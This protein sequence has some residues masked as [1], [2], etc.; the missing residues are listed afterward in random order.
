M[1]LQDQATYLDEIA[2]SYEARGY[3]VQFL[4]F[5]YSAAWLPLVTATTQ[6]QTITIDHDS[7]FIC[8]QLGQSVHDTATPPVFDIQPRIQVRFILGTAQKR[9]D[10]IPI[11][12]PTAWGFGGQPTIL[13]KP[14]VLP[15]K[16]TVE[17]ELEAVNGIPD[18]NVN[19][20]LGGVK[21]FLSGA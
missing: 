1:L 16:T 11:I 6:S 21:A 12:L 9:L 3:R 17:L 15:A 19:L 13:A 18:R 14:L 2:A 20:T 7:D 5:F 4:P 10:N 8:T